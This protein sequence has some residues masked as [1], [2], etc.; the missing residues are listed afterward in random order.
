MVN[1]SS[2][3]GELSS[4]LIFVARSRRSLLLANVSSFALPCMEESLVEHFFRVFIWCLDWTGADSARW[5]L[6]VEADRMRSLGSELASDGERPQ[7]MW[8]LGTLRLGEEDMI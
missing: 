4:D 2:L 5:M 6:F 8:R 3:T 1:C 7:D